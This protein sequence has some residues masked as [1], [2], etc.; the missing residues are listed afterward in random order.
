MYAPGLE[1]GS[2]TGGPVVRFRVPA[3]VLLLSF[4][5]VGSVSVLGC[6]DSPRLPFHPDAASNLVVNGRFE[7]PRIS[8]FEYDSYSAG[9]LLGG[10]TIDAGAVDHLSGRIWLPADGAQ[11]LDMDGSCG[12]GALHQDLRTESGILYNLH[13]AL[14][15]NPNG[16]PTIKAL[17]VSWGDT[18]LDT[19]RFDTTGGTK[20]DPGWIP[21]DYAVTAPAAT[22]R[23]TFR[24]LSAGC[25]GALLDA[26]SVRKIPAI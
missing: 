5:C 2:C 23:L 22:T 4:G 8:S 9:A 11:S 18:V 25:Y 15:G 14:A 17:E 7:R 12:T 24:S 6:D 10:W 3:L 19:V 20:G 1:A 26:V 13:F 21:Y 16:T